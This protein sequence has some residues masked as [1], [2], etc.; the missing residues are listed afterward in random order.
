MV[1]GCE[2]KADSRYLGNCGNLLGREIKI[3]P[4]GFE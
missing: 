3:E 4:E 2:T 1:I